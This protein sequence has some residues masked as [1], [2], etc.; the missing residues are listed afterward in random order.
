MV[1]SVSQMELLRR[2]VHTRTGI[3]YPPR[4]N[5]FLESRIQGLMRRSGYTSAAVLLQELVKGNNAL[6]DGFIKS[7]TTNHTYFFREADHF[8]RMI[9]EMRKQGLK[10]PKIWVAA[11]STGEEVYSIVIALREKGYLNY[12]IMASDI[13]RNNLLALRKGVYPESR[14]HYMSPDRI[15]RWFAPVMASGRNDPVWQVRPAMKAGIFT[16]VLNLSDRLAFETRFDFIFCRN[17]LM[18][19]QSETQHAVVEMLG[20]NL[21]DRGLLF[22]GHSENIL[23]PCR[24]LEPVGMATFRKKV[25][26]GTTEGS[27]S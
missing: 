3:Y 16:R 22:I 26:N 21:E 10:E 6:W 11:S 17:V 4:K 20:D 27:D 1:L 2:L 13:N 7:F 19:F 23:R 5:F 25:A 8:D 9:D 24:N 15:Q 14:M 12:R 18:Y